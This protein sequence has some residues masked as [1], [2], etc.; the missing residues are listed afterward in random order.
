MCWGYND[1]QDAGPI[2][3]ELTEKSSEEDG[4]M[5]RQ[6]QH[7]GYMRLRQGAV[8]A[9]RGKCTQH[10]G[11]SRVGTSEEET[12]ELESSL[13]SFCR[14]NDPSLIYPCGKM[15]FHMV[16]LDTFIQP[17]SCTNIEFLPWARH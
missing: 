4:Q 12:Y 2:F 14:V 1:K 13:K 5:N 3:K 9:W 11:S 8:R 15:N 10:L 6:L 17:G 7:F 16:T